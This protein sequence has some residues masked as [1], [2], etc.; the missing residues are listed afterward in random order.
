M[1]NIAHSGA[2]RARNVN[3]L[4]FML[5]WDQYKF[6]KKCVV[7]SKDELVFLHPMGSTSHAVHSGTFGARNINA[8]FFM[9]G[10]DQYRLHKKRAGTRYVELVFL[11]PVGCA[12]HV[13]HSVAPET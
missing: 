3:A 10:W 13:V 2:C 5:G 6:N 1:G 11:H 12:G 7:T 9:L 4:F 8:Q